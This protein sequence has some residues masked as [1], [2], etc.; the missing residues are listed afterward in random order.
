[1]RLIKKELYFD[2]SFRMTEILTHDRDW[3][4][5]MDWNLVRYMQDLVQS[6]QLEF[7]DGLIATMENHWQRTSEIFSENRL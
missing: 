5:V 1:V 6:N 2:G 4:G 7:M 3:C